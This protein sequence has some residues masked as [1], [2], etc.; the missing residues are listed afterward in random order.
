[1]DCRGARADDLTALG[2]LALA[3]YDE[4]NFAV[5]SDAPAA[6]LQALVGSPEAHVTVVDDATELVGFAVTTTSFGLENGQIAELEDLHVVPRAR[7]HGLAELLID[8]SARWARERGCRQLELVIAPNGLDVTH[9]HR[10]YLA[11]SFKDEG[12]R[13]LSRPLRP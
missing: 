7:R 5:E 3:L 4:D 13:L 11:R 10:Y 1:V 12:R 2:G 9:L 6:N 8:D